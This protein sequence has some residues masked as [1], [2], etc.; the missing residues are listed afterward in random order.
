MNLTRRLR[1]RLAAGAKARFLSSSP[2][3]AAS[4]SDA[5]PSPQE[6]EARLREELAAAH[7]LQV[8]YGLD[9]L[10]WNLLS[11]RCPW[12]PEHFL[13]TPGDKL[14]CEVEPD[15]LVVVDT[16][17]DEGS[18]NV[19]AN[20]IHAAFYEARLDVGAVVHNHSRACM[21]VACLAGESLRYLT[22]DAAGFYGQ[23]GRLSIIS[24]STQQRREGR[25]GGREG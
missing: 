8:R 23:V 2:V 4:A 15:D 16:V 9:D 21:G 14:F 6:Q 19:T 12:S 5:S 7:L 18:A 10:V 1:S 24:P 17:A 3:A 22:Q 25:K 11:A 13:V 20:V